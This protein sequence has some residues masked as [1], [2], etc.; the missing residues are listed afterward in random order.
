MIKFPL[1]LCFYYASADHDGIA[2]QAALVGGAY[3]A[4]KW[5]SEAMHEVLS[6]EVGDKLE[7]DVLIVEPSGFRTT[8]TSTVIVDTVNEAY[9]ARSLIRRS[10]W[11]RTSMKKAWTDTFAGT[12]PKPRG[13]FSMRL[14]MGTMEQKIAELQRDL[15]ATQQDSI[16]TNLD[17]V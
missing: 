14:L 10:L 6:R 15:E 9:K 1:C 4:S 13:R 12:L 2:S 8:F 5:A 16:C 17:G 11:C 7:I 3:V